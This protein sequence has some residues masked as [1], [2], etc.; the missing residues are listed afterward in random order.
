MLSLRAQIVRRSPEKKRK[1]FQHRAAAGRVDDDRIQAAI[2][3]CARKT[4]GGGPRGR[5]RLVV[6]AHVMRQRAA[7]AGTG[8]HRDLDAEPRQ[9]PDRR[10]VYLRCQRLLRA[11][12]KQRHPCPPL[13]LRRMHAGPQ[14]RGR[15]GVGRRQ[16][17]HRPQ[18]PPE[19]VPCGSRSRAAVRA[20]LP[21]ARG[22]TAPDAAAGSEQGPQR[23]VVPLA[24]V[25]A[26]DMRPRVVDQVHVVDA[27]RA[28]GH[29]GE[30]GEAAVDVA[31]HLLG[32]RAAGFQHVLDQVD[33]PA[34]AVEL[35]AEQ[36]EGRAGRGAEPAMDAGAQDLVGGGDIGVAQLFSGEIRLHRVSPAGH[37]Q[38]SSSRATAAAR[39]HRQREQRNATAKQAKIV[40][41]KAARQPTRIWKH[42]QELGDQ[43]GS[44]H[45]TAGSSPRCCAT[46][47]RSAPRRRPAAAARRSRSGCGTCR[48]QPG[49]CGRD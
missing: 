27:G 12:G 43:A 46:A 30:A 25:G 26:L 49:G 17:Q 14:Q 23:P 34:R 28:G 4:L 18:P 35:V 5:G 37:R 44:G 7:A 19:R 38:R 24:A 47:D 20:V 33:A 21:P 39:K 41:T 9:Q 42:Q 29:A 15:L 2:G 8:G 45:M 6:A 13:A 3:C 48:S 10:R 31:H 32:R 16:R 11:A 36:Q 1:I 40:G 22:G